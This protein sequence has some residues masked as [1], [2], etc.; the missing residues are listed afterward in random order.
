M[1]LRQTADTWLQQTLGADVAFRDGQW[2]AIS[3]LVERHE[4]TLVVQR[5]GWGKSLVYFMATRL[6]RQQG[7]GTTL[8]VSPLLALMRNQI[9]AA[10]RWGLK[11]ETINSTNIEDHAII[12]REL[13]DGELDLL[14]ISPERLGNERF[15]LE[16]WP[17][18]KNQVGMMVIDEAHCISDWGHDF[19]P[20]YRRIMH[21]LDDLPPKTPVLGTT[22]TANDRVVKDV[23]DILGATMNIQRGALTRDSL[24]LYTYTEP[25]DHPTRL[26]LLAHL[27][28]TIPGCGIIYCT[29]TH[30]CQVVSEWLQMQ[31]IDAQPYYA[32]VESDGADTRIELEN[33]LMKNQVKALVASVALGMGFDKPDLSFV[34]HYQQPGNIIS[35]YQQIGRAGRNISEAHIILMHGS[36]DEEIQRYFID[37]AFPKPKQIESAIHALQEHGTLKQSELQRYVNASQSNLDKILTHLEV[38]RIIQRTDDG[39][40][41]L[42]DALARPDYD[43]WEDVTKQRETELQQ[44]EAYIQHKGCLMRFIAEALDDPTNVQPCGRCKNCRNSQSKFVPDP[45]VVDV[46]RRFMREGRPIVIEPRRR[47]PSGLPGMKRTIIEHINQPGIALCGYYDTGWAEIVKKGR[48][49]TNFYPEELLQEAMTVLKGHFSTIDAPPQWVTC[50]PSLRRPLLVSNFAERLSKRLGL[51]YIPILKHIKQH[52]EQASLRNS[53]QQVMNTYNVFKVE[54]K[55]SP[56]PVLLV[57]DVADSKWT[58]TVVGSLLR[59]NGSGPVHPFVLATTNTRS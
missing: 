39:G 27:M 21:I 23:S 34:I 37:T 18:L 42:R 46:A 14:L 25:M 47:W 24:R 51:P 15:Q 50:V 36:G 16:V 5:T 38:E 32:D 11:A 44:M 57:D 2:E 30:D 31:G 9:E 35:Y 40:Y 20:N 3:A 56:A 53:Y 54:D 7:A 19:R 12:Q 29:T 10:R 1:A 8:L 13:L 52:P 45:K 49:E 22:A 28:K 55:P 17:K 6:L 43:R 59:K 58:L 26:T 33:R 4:R 48:F 41:L